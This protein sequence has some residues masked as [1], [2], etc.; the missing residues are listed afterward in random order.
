LF[1]LTDV[2]GEAFWWVIGR[3]NGQNVG[4]GDAVYATRQEAA[5]ELKSL[6]ELLDNSIA[7]VVTFDDPVRSL[8]WLEPLLHVG[9]G[10]ALRR[11]GCLEPLEGTS[12]RVSPAV[13]L[14][15]A[16]LGLLLG[17]GLTIDA[18]LDRQAEQASL[19]AARLAR[20]D[21]E[22]RRLELLAH[23][24]NHFDQTW[25]DAPLAMDVAVPC[26]EALLA[27]PT[28]VNGWQLSEASC[29]GRAMS[30]VWA[31]KPQA[32]FL[33]LPSHASLK[34]PQVAVSRLTLASGR[35][36]RTGQHY[37]D[38]LT[39][40]GVTRHLYEITQQAGS[41]LRLTFRKPETRSIERVQLTAPWIKGEWI[42]EAVPGS[43]LQ[44]ELWRALS[45][46]PGLTLEQI[47]V[48]DGTWSLYGAVY[49]KEK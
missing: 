38:L 1:A 2:Q 11:R 49:V 33:L 22:Q 35:T 17:I 43:L 4:Q 25:T 12:R 18:W 32:S 3:Q 30:I 16:G 23:P 26:M 39:R 40:E 45:A 13:L 20:L 41:R 7:E 5:Q 34:T 44:E 8:A 15:A 27:Q 29:S 36:P 47:R 28:V 42:L 14:G 6:N 21:K 31:H 46:L 10:A 9:V 19:E 24:E 37:P 48:K